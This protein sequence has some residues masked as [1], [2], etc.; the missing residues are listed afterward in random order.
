[1]LADFYRGYKL[2][3]MHKSHSYLNTFEWKSKYLFPML[4]SVIRLIYRESSNWD[5]FWANYTQV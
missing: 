2:Q 1:M 5:A 3:Q 4:L